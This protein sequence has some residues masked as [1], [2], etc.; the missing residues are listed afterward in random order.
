MTDHQIQLSDRRYPYTL[1]KSKR[2]RYLRLKLAPSG[3]LSLVVP[4]GVSLAMAQ[5]FLSSQ[6]PWVES[7]LQTL[8]PQALKPWAKPKLLDLVYLDEHW[9][10]KYFPQASDSITLRVAVAE[11]LECYGKV[12]DVE[13]LK[14]TLGHWLKAKAEK[15][16]S[17]RLKW[18]AE[19]HGFHYQR[20]SIR[21]QKTRWGSCSAKKNINLNYKLLFLDQA[22]V[23][24]VL[25]H[26][27]CHTIEMNHSLRF[28]ALVADCDV[29]Y[30]A[31]DRRLNQVGRSLPL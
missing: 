27:L 19:Q 15:A 10:I 4:N 30:K 11:Q 1:V 13:L 16:L 20:L 31:H 7:K 3:E 17:V 26:E 29:N 14:K 24:Y 12:D 5:A 6:T 21:G 22:L 8:P 23:D 25:I 2:A 18:Q 28:W 9:T